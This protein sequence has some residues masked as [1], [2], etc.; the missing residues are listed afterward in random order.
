MPTLTLRHDDVAVRVTADDGALAWLVEFTAP[1]FVVDA[2]ARPMAEVR[3]LADGAR[4]DAWARAAAADGVATPCFRLDTQVVAW[5]AVRDGDATV[6]VDGKYAAAYRCHAGGVDVVAA[7]GP[8]AGRMP[9]LRVVREVVSEHLRRRPATVQLH[10]AGVVVDGR[11]LV[12][13]GAKGAGKTTLLAHLLRGG[14]TYLA[15]DRVVVRGGPAGPVAAGLPTVV[16][17]RAGTFAWF[18]ALA[19]GVPAVPHPSHLTRAEAAVAHAASGP[20]RADERARMSPAHFCAALGAPTAPAAPLAA[21]VLPRLDA[22]VATWAVA[23]ATSAAARA[24]IDGV[25]YG[26]DGAAAGPDGATPF[27]ALAGGGAPRDV[28]PVLDG[29]AADVPVVAL[30]LG[31]RAYDAPGGAAALIAAVTAAAR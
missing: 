17:V 21:I 3:L 15:N 27:E 29:L 20:A 9:L 28:G 12:C 7:P 25:R 10:G 8:L 22:G 14:A 13:A 1:S 4:R 6:L 18:P 31:P 16:S 30:A 24:A 26:H 23:R 19:A 5:P 2:G 11:A